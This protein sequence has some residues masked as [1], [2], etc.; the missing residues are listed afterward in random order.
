MQ[1]NFEAIEA[2]V[3]ILMADSEHN[4]ESSALPYLFS[5]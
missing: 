1:Y 3:P 5:Q 2:K 4:R